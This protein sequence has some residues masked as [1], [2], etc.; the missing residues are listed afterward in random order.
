MVDISVIIPTCNQEERL[1]LV[2]CGLESQSLPGDRYEVIVVD[3]GC[4]DGTRDM[5]AERM[6]QGRGHLRFLPAHPRKGRSAARNRGLEAAAGELVVFL[7][8]DALPAPDLLDRYRL[9]FE[10]HGPECLLCGMQYS[11]AELEFFQDPQTGELASDVPVASV[12]RDFVGVRRHELV[13]TEEMV[14]NDFDA[15]RARAREGGYPFEESKRRQEE[16]RELLRER[17]DGECG[18]LAF[19][20]HNGGGSR[21]QLL[22]A[23]GFD[24]DIPFNEG[25]ELAYRMRRHH[26]CRIRSVPADTYHLYHYHPFLDPEGGKREGQI[27]YRAIEYMVDK[28]DDDR[29]RLLYFWYA[30]LWPD[31]YI[32]QE[33]LVTDLLEFDRLYSSLSFETWRQYQVILKQHPSQFIEETT[34]VVI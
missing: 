20:P 2:L 13:V 16:A 32:P 8:G 23:G 6:T 18:W 24:E 14:V 1:R 19:I 30:H 33:A 12:V 3:D 5:V 7:D 27:R 34:E 4:T 25:W 10:E 9:A 26:G 29:I 11:L 17:P 22:Q 21:A 31:Y 28:H 15:I